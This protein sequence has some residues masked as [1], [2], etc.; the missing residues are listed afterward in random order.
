M[1]ATKL[2]QPMGLGPN[3]RGLSAYHLRRACEESLRRL[4]TDHIDLYQMHHIDRDAL[5]GDLA[6]DGAAGARQDHLRWQQ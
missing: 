2:Y 4:Q 6:G 3:D 1:L 5:G